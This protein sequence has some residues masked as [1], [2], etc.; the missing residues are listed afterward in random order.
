MKTK[1]KLSVLSDLLHSVYLAASAG[2]FASLIRP[3]EHFCADCKC[4]RSVHNCSKGIYHLQTTNSWYYA[5]ACRAG[6]EFRICFYSFR[7]VLHRKAFE[8]VIEATA[9]GWAFG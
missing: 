9:F 4:L 5:R 3:F 6:T 7:H 2:F 1:R 8:C